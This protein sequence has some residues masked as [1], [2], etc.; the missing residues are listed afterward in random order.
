MIDRSPKK[1]KGINMN[2]IIKTKKR[3]WNKFELY[4]GSVQEPEADIEFLRD[5]FKS[6]R[7]RDAL[8]FRE[9]FCG[10][11]FLSCEWVK[12]SQNHEAVG[13]DLC[14]E[15]LDY[16][17]T[18]HW[19]KLKPDQKS[20]MQ[21]LEKDVLES[22][23]IHAD[24]VAAFNFSFWIFKTRQELMNYFKAVRKSMNEDSIFVMDTMG[25]CDASELIEESKDCDKGFTYYWECEFFNPINN[26][27]K[28]AIHYK[29]PGKRKV[30]R[31]FTYDWRVWGLAELRELLIDAG[32]SKTIVYWEGDDEEDDGGNGEFTAVEEAEDADAWIAYVVALP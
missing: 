1:F 31:V 12:Q 16:G 30:K 15:T 20:R 9:D 26:N 22:T 3:S 21:Y 17:K 4:E 18:H 19:E 14:S 24:I 28:Y 11:G 5:T 23:G 32:F 7:N 25:G 8:T 27:A 29:V 6:L 2:Q 13:I 10:T